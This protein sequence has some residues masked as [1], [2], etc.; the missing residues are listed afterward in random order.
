MGTLGK[1]PC[2]CVQMRAADWC[3]LA[4]VGVYSGLAG[5]QSYMKHRKCCGKKIKR[6]FFLRI[7]RLDKIIISYYH[8][9]NADGTMSGK[10]SSHGE[11][12]G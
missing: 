6:I 2:Q 12:K 5:G 9:I 10:F 4:P 8:A 1:K 3:T 11:Y 7:M